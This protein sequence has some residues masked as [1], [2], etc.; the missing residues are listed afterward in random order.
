MLVFTPF[1][2]ALHVPTL[3][4]FFLSFQCFCFLLLTPHCSAVSFVGLIVCIHREEH[5]GSVIDVTF[6][7]ANGRA[8]SCGRC[9]F[10]TLL[11]WRAPSSYV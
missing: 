8:P 7:V 5:T 9:Y 1:L 2:L 4:L 6:V 3:S 11:P 10:G